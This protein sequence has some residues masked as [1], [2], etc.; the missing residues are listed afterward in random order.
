MNGSGALSIP[1]LAALAGTD[2]ID[3]RVLNTYALLD[4]ILLSPATYG[5]TD[6][7]DPCL[8]GS[9][10]CANP[11]QYLFWDDQHP[12]AAG[13]A[14]VAD[15]ALAVLAPEPGSMTMFGVGLFALVLIRRGVTA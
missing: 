14:I 10:P 12:T 3:L 7:T 6:V 1:S 15:A 5:F 13:H 9:T 4:S 8:V 11:S 2:G